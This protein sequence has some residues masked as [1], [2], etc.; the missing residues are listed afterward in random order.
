MLRELK[1]RN[2]RGFADHRLPLNDLTVMVGK[3]N[4]G[5]TT[6][7]EALRLLSIVVSRY[8]FLSYRKPPAWTDLPQRNFGVA[9]SLRNLEI[10]FQAVFHRYE[11]PPAQIQ[12]LFK[13]NSSVSIYLNENEEIHAVIKAPDGNII[14]GKNQAEKANLPLASIMPQVAPL[15]PVEKILT[16]D[17]VQGALSSS[18]ASSHFR[19]QLNLL[20]KQYFSKFQQVVE[21]TWSGVRVVELVGQG[22]TLQTQLDLYIRNEDFEGEVGLMGHG[23]QMWLQTMW[24]LTRSAGSKTVILDEPDVYMHPDLQR[25]I[26]RFLRDRFPQTI[27]TTHSVEI[28]SEVDPENILII[29]K[30]GDKSNFATSLQA[31]QRITDNIG[32]VHNVH[33][34]RLSSS[35]RFLL[36][37]GKDIR[38]LKHFQDIIFPRSNI[39]IEIIPSMEI[40]GW[41]GWNYAIGSS[42]TLQN[43]MGEKIQTYCILDRDYHI[44]E[45]IEDR[46]QKANEQDI[47]LHIWSQ[48]EIENY[49]L[50]PSVIHRYISNQVANRT[51]PPDLQ[52]VKDEIEKLAWDMENDVFDA[53][54]NEYLVRNRKKGSSGANKYAREYMK[55][56]KD[57]GSIIPIV[58]GKSLLSKLSSWSQSE[59]SVQISPIGLIKEFH[60]SEIYPEMK[61]VITAIEQLSIFDFS[62]ETY[63]Q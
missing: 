14:K 46:L 11:R 57:K 49:L 54:S 15:Q 62:A 36:V 7:V 31:V 39:P 38:F 12:G 5:K 20:Y 58:S 1:I 42:M 24:F 45:E 53:V 27:L 10:N 60:A 32:S 61:Y 30:A 37:E 26:I 22:K 13:N 25:N 51:P 63:H 2:F 8:K 21:D 41:G 4:A 18:L 40:G 3:N 23:L 19:N 29:D 48:K 50:S 56:Y 6:L 28:M 59:F 9:P 33:L 55:P 47:N 44:L 34:A 52:E 17:Y 16:S 43:S 35:R